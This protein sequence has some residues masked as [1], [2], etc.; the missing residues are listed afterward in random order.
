MLAVSSDEEVARIDAPT[1]RAAGI[2]LTFANW[3]GVLAPPGISASSRESMIR[4]LTE[5]HDTRRWQEALVDN[6]WTD[7]FV[8]GADVEG[9]LDEQDDRVSTTLARLGLI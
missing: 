7:S 9:F 2:D 3:R 1:L 8:T 4:L 5:L 6:G